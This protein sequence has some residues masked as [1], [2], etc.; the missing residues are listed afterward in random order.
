[1]LLRRT[2]IGASP[3]SLVDAKAHLRWPGED[4]DAALE[5]MLFAAVA[6]VG[7]MAGR[8]MTSET[9]VLSCD[10]ISGDLVLPKSPV[11]AVTS[12]KYYDATDTLQT[13]T[14]SDYYVFTSDDYTTVRPKS[15][16]W[17]IYSTRA[18]ALQVTFTA[19]YATLPH[20]LRQAVFLALGDMYMNRGDDSAG[21]SAAA[22]DAL[23]SLHRLGWVA[24]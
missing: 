6:M 17:P 10:A 19:G 7:E 22:I 16:A 20:E 13:A 1:M 14:L 3:I 18:D 2:A 23:V 8:A 4:D 11:T 15:R 21:K 5:R 12:V 9:W 24:A